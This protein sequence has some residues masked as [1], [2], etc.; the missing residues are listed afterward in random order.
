MTIRAVLL[1]VGGVILVP[2]PAIYQATFGAAGLGPDEEA[3]R[4]GHYAGVAAMDRVGEVDW[5]V[6]FTELAV[7]CGALHNTVASV[8]EA[9]G[10]CHQPGV[11]TSVL[12]GAREGLQALAATGASVAMVSNSDGT[13][14]GLLRDAEVCQVGP[15]PGVEVAVVVDSHVVGVEKPDPRIFDFALSVVGVDAADA[16][17]VGDTVTYDVRGARA[18][19]LHPLHLDPYDLCPVPRDHDHVRSLGDV[20]AW[21]SASA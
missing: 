2:D 19:G 1:D 15:G 9:L 21:V 14:E 20:A 17:Y 16:A 3:V 11:W 13:V 18:A 6:Y 12:P 4:R 8:S 7:A 5:P 10:A